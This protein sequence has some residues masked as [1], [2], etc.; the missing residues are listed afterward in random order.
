MLCEERVHVEALA[1]GD[2]GAKHT[3]LP[4]LCKMNLE[5]LRIVFEPKRYHGVKDVL[6]T[7]RFAFLELALLSRFG[8]NEADKLGDAFLDTLLGVLRDFCRG[9]H[10][11]LHDTR[12]VGNLEGVF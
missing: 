2:H 12:H 11:V 10:R 5:R 7:N 9:G 6:S 8:R 1:A 3:H 4:Q